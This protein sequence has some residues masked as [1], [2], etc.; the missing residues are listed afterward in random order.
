MKSTSG[1]LVS[2]GIGGVVTFLFGGQENDRATGD[3]S[4]VGEF[5]KK[6]F[7]VRCKYGG[8]SRYDDRDVADFPHRAL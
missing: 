3:F 6:K 1:K 7:T 4:P 5:P 8:K 2:L